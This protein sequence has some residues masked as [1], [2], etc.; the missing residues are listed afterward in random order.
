MLPSY[1]DAYHNVGGVSTNTGNNSPWLPIAVPNNHDESQLRGMPERGWDSTSQL[2][3]IT[4]SSPNLWKSP[5]RCNGPQAELWPRKPNYLSSAMSNNYRAELTGRIP[6]EI[7]PNIM[8]NPISSLVKQVPLQQNFRASP[9]PSQT[10]L[11]CTLPRQGGHFLNH[12]SAAVKALPMNSL[13]KS[14]SAT[15]LINHHTVS[16]TV[17][18]EALDGPAG[19]N[20][21]MFRADSNGFPNQDVSCREAGN[22]GSSLASKSGCA[23][24]DRIHEQNNILQSTENRVE[25]KPEVMHSKVSGNSE[26]SQCISEQIV[27]NSVDSYELKFI[28]ISDRLGLKVKSSPNMK[29][30]VTGQRLYGFSIEV[31]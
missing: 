26:D 31:T 6:E 16:A 12:T 15:A 20:L 28:E 10:P 29:T 30:D 22:P 27:G 21:S 17:S 2:L 23:S 19:N 24:R 1:P 3:E 7:D 4:P 18:H 11:F 13:S 9:L 8:G 25:R 14:L 5:G